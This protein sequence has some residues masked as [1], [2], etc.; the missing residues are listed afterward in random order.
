MAGPRKQRRFHPL[1]FVRL[2]LV[3]LRPGNLRPPKRWEMENEEAGGPQQVGPSSLLQRR[4]SGVGAVGPGPRQV[5]FL[6]GD[7]GASVEQPK[8]IAGRDHHVFGA[9][10]RAHPRAG[11][12]GA[13]VEGPQ[14]NP[15][16]GERRC[17]RSL[18]ARRPTEQGEQ[19]CRRCKSARLHHRTGK[20]KNPALES[21]PLYN[22]RSLSLVSVQL[23]IC[24]WF[25]LG[26]RTEST[27]PFT[28]PAECASTMPSL[29]Y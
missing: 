12:A 28:L 29:S 22:R 10:P 25:V 19:P 1:G 26:S 20:A 3:W 24:W 14:G 15:R 18:G 16:V 4:R 5:G 17:H 2:G 7:A 23:R 21:C 27:A 11:S 13:G 8:G 9:G 6:D